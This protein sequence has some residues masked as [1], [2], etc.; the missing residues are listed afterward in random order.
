MQNI[1]LFEQVFNK[2]KDKQCMSLIA[3]T[4]NSCSLYYYISK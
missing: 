4:V 2:I 1:P 3:T